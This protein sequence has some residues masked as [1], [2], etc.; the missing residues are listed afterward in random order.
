[1]NVSRAEVL[2]IELAHP[3]PRVQPRFVR[4]QPPL[5][6]VQR[7]EA[8]RL[9]DARCDIDLL[10][11]EADSNRVAH[12]LAMSERMGIRNVWCHGLWWLGDDGRWQAIDT[13]RA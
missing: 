5:V 8:Q 1:V 11:A 6:Y 12:A 3:Q 2:M 4:Y 10:V 13:D 9:D 7:T